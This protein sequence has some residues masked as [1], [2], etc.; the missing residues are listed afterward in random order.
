MTFLK[1]Y[2]HAL[3]VEKQGA[4]S[5][6]FLDTAVVDY[7]LTILLSFATTY[8]F[9]I[10]AVLTTIFWFTIGVVLHYIFG[11][12]TQSLDYLKTVFV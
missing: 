10:P 1:K 12:K 8:L 5:I 6:R 7:I 11:V 3:G 4:H 2:R 9:R